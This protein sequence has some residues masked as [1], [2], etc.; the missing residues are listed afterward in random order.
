MFGHLAYF[1]VMIAVG[2]V[3]A[4]RRLDVLLLR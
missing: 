2:V 1:A 4:A 3:V